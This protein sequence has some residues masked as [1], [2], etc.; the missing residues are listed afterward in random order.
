M[1]ARI[2][3]SGLRSHGAIGG[4]G[5]RE[6]AHLKYM[7][8]QRQRKRRTPGEGFLQP[9]K[10]ILKVVKDLRWITRAAPVDAGAE[11]RLI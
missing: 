3:Q 2:V 7:S 4:T 11:N 5:G 8:R 9:G 10:F 1:L 6:I